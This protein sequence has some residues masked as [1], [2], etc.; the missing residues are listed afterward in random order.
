MRGSFKSTVFF[1]LFSLLNVL[2][3][4]APFKHFDKLKEFVSMKLPP[5]FPVRVG[6]FEL[7][8]ISKIML[9]YYCKC[10]NLNSYSVRYLFLLSLDR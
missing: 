7:I 3:V 4:I 5:G 8:R 6:M 2:E 10:C 1:F 9:A